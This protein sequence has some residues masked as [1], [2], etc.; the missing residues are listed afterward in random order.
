MSMTQDQVSY[1]YIP[2]NCVPSSSPDA[3]DLKSGFAWQL[4]RRGLSVH[5]DCVGRWRGRRATHNRSFSLLS[6]MQ[7]SRSE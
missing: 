5:Q 1:G 6:R 2:Q 3:T 4:A 7:C